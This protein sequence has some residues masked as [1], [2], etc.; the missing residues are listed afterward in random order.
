MMRKCEICDAKYDDDAND[1]VD[2]MHADMI[3]LTQ[4]CNHC[5]VIYTDLATENWVNRICT[6]ARQASEGRLSADNS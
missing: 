3:E 4:I 5:W 1:L 2:R 6:E